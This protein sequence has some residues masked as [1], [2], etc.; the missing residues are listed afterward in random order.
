MK[1]DNGQ[2]KFERRRKRTF[3]P[4]IYMLAEMILAWL[5]LSVINISFEMQTWGVGSHILLFLAFIYSGHKTLGI[6]E[7]QKDYKVA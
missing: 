2:Y 1:I 4:T 7:R 6:Y 5:L 3:T